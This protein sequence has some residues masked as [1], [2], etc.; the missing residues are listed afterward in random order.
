[1][2]R[3]NNRVLN[4]NII[5]KY[6]YGKGMITKEVGKDFRILHACDLHLTPFLPGKNNRTID[7]LDKAIDESSPDLV[8]VNGDLVWTFFNKSMLRSFADFMED[9]KV[10]WSY[11]LGNHD[12]GFLRDKNKFVDVLDDYEHCLFLKGP[13]DLGVGNYFLTLSRDRKPVFSLTFVDTSDNKISAEQCQWLENGLTFIKDR[14]S[15]Y[16]KNMIFMHVPIQEI[17]MLKSRPYDGYIT[18]RINPLDE[19]DTFFSTVKDNKS[20]VAIFNGHDHVNNFSG[21]LDN[22]FLMSTLACGY[23]A[24]NKRGLDKGFVVIDIDTE[25]GNFTTNNL[26]ANDLVQ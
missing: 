17:E 8:V 6:D 24:F 23:G 21:E 11:T 16:A 15:A 5:M 4:K 14:S 2:G 22:I 9:K 18:K 26:Y 25:N 19:E 1:M 20:T 7:L 10:Y 3:I 13:E 12:C